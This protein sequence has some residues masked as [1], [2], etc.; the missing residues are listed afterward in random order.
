[1][2]IA[3]LKFEM[4]ENC[5]KCPLSYIDEDWEY[6]RFTCIYTGNHLASEGELS[7]TRDETCPLKEGS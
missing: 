6:K 7:L 4:P 1:M 5:I 3:V 2:S